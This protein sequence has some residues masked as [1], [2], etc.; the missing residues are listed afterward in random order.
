MNDSVVH[1]SDVLDN[2]D[3]DTLVIEMPESNDLPDV[4]GEFDT[5][6]ITTSTGVP[7]NVSKEQ[8]R[9]YE[10]PETRVVVTMSSWSS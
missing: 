4:A 5:E 1:V 6:E 8:T 7:R 9:G 10:F 2:D 3:Y